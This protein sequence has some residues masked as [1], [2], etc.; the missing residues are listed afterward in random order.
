MSGRMIPWV[1]GT[2]VL[3][4]VG[5]RCCRQPAPPPVAAVRV[6]PPGCNAC[7]VPGAAPAAVPGGYPVAPPPPAPAPGALAPV[8]QAPPPPAPVAPGISRYTPPAAAWQPAPDRGGVRLNVPAETPEPPREPVRASAPPQAPAPMPQ[9]PAP[10]PQAPAAAP[11]T[12]S[13]SLPSGIPQFAVAKEKEQVATGLKPLLDG[14]DWLQANGYK[15]VL[16]LRQPG[17]DDSADRRQ[18]EKRGLKYLSLEVSPATLNQA[19][20]DDFNRLVADPA[21]QPLFV[22]DRDGMVAGGL[23]YLHFRTVDRASDEEARARAARLG[24]K[25]DANGPHR[26]MWLAIQKLLSEHK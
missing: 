22:Y 11:V 7:G 6:P 26:A 17:D 16:N 23:W 5:C 14:L 3:G 24:L 19:V 2:I 9:A 21:N 25:E 12:P 13:P 15:T 8:P 4:A 18:V 10:M 20:V 1:V